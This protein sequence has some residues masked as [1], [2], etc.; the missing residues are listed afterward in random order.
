MS[1]DR[2]VPAVIQ[3]RRDEFLHVKSVL[4]RKLLICGLVMIALLLLVLALFL[5]SRYP[6]LP[7]AAKVHAMGNE[8]ALAYLSAYKAEEILEDWGE[9]DG[10]SRYSRYEDGADMVRYLWKLPD[11]LD[12]LQ[13]YVEEQTGR[14]TG[15]SCTQVFRGYIVHDST[16]LVWGTV[17]P[18]AYEQEAAYGD[19]IRINLASSRP[20]VVECLEPIIP[21]LIYYEGE[22]IPPAAEGELPSI[23][24]VKDMQYYDYTLEPPEFD[25]EP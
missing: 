13:L 18:L 16:D 10:T 12:H 5:T 22:V 21:I 11:S 6:F 23:N 1:L 3:E 8:D 24:S 4:E 15:V 2:P 14:V 9:P 17:T 7:S 25:E 19:L 20:A